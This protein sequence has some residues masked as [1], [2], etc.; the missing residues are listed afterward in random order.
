MNPAQRFRPPT[1]CYG[2][3]KQKNFLYIFLIARPQFFQLR[4]RKFFCF[5]ILLIAE[6]RKRSHPSRA[7]GA[8]N[9][10]VKIPSPRPPSFLPACFGDFDFLADKT[11]HYK[12]SRAKHCVTQK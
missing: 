5:G 8:V 3:P 4:K 11:L 10:R 7:F 12:H 2:K 1:L 6:L 9:R